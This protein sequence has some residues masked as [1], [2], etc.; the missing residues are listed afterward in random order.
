MRAGGSETSG[1]RAVFLGAKAAIPHLRARGGGVIL[2][3]AS[4]HSVVGLP[5]YAAYQAAKGG[6]LSLTR[7]LARE[8]A[9]DNI[10]VVAIIFFVSSGSFIGIQLRPFSSLIIRTPTTPPIF[11]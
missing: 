3:T 11:F 6:V 4:V 2:N 1:D 8:L 10:R 9:K 7:G 5:G